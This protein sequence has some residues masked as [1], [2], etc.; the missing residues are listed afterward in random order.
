V[1]EFVRWLESRKCELDEEEEEM[2][3]RG[4]FTGRSV[5]CFELETSTLFDSYCLSNR[6]W[7]KLF[8]K[9]VRFANGNLVGKRKMW[10]WK[11]KW[12]FIG[13]L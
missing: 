10:Q 9:M 7:S 12:L 1:V 6:L 2:G 13:R 5:I 3:I 8:V 4:V 11:W